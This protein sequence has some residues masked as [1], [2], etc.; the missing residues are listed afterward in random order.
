MVPLKYPN[1]KKDADPDAHVQVFNFAVKE[2]AKTSK[3]YII[4]AFNYTLKN[5][6]SNRCHNYMSKFPDYIFLKLT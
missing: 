5:T 3:K 6:T 1:L 2:N 4:N